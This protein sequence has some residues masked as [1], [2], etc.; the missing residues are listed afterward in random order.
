MSTQPSAYMAGPPSM[1]AGSHEMRDYYTNQD[2]PRPTPHTAPSITPYLGLRA[3]LSQIWINRWTILLLLVLARTLIAIS[4]INYDLTSARREAHTACSGVEAKGSA[5]ASMPHYM[6]PGVNE[7]AATGVEKDVNGLMEMTT[8]SV[9]G[10]EEIVVFVINMMTS[11]YLCL[12]TL[13]VSGSL[14]VALKVVEDAQ[15]ALNKSL[16]AIGDDM[17]SNVGAF[18]SVYNDFIGKLGSSLTGL[19]ESTVTPPKID[20]NS[21]LD[22]LHNLQLPSNLDQGLT[23]LNSSIPTFAQV[24]NFTDNAIRLPFEEVKQLI[25]QSMGGYQ[26]DRSIFPVPAKE[27]LTFCSDNNGINDFFDELAALV[28]LARKI[29]I[30]VLIIAAVAVCIPMAWREIKRWRTMQERSQLVHSN[31]HDPMDVVYIVSRPYTSTAGIKAASRFKSPRHQILVRWVF[32]YATSAPAL[33]VLSLALAGLFSCVCQ[34][35]LL[36][37]LEKEIPDLTNQVSSFADKV[38]N[39]LNNA[40]E[41]WSI[42]VNKVIDSTNQD[43]NKNLF[44]WVNITTG[45]LNDTLN[46]FVNGTMGVLNETFGG[47]VLYQPITEVLNCLLLLKIAGI[48]KALTWISDNAHIDI[49]NLPNNTFTLGA[50]TSIASD[51]SNPSDSFLSTVG[52]QA[53]DDISAAVVRFTTGLS[54]A[55]RTEALI[56]TCV[57]LT[58]VAILHIG[59]IRALILWFGREKT[60]GEGGAPNLIAHPQD[61]VRGLA[62]TTVERP[63]STEPAPK[64]SAS[65][66]AANLQEDEYQEQKFG[67]AG[68]R[69]YGDSLRREATTGG[70]SRV[71]SHGEVWGDSKR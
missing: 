21:T 63:P 69:N 59:I 33:F 37:S 56:W 10:V 52:A 9:T 25:N 57:L 14:H 70:H 2:P 31:A 8:L 11:T 18:D 15:R 38:V 17:S 65:A 47:T 26:F 53:S 44:S 41:Q 29:F 62:M 16:Q 23:K 71:S 32:A 48:E 34:T 27:E 7:L 35:I 42:G 43:I 1:P 12:I 40:S 61:E 39:S 6:S 46:V 3:R 45:A 49:S 30:A 68:Q 51:N 58:W 50:V 22:A 64:Y 20:L 24:Q 67:F 66:D 13:A 19:L 36:K 60:R 55:I 4:G 54:N 28:E 5:M